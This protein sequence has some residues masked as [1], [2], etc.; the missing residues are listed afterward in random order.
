M[1]ILWLINIELPEVSVLLKEKENPWG[2]WLVNASADLAV[3]EGIQLSIA[4]PKFGLTNFL[5]LKGENIQFYAFP[6]IL[7]SDQGAI[8][9]SSHLK[10]ILEQ[11]KPDIVHIFGT[12]FA[13]S[14]AM[15][16]LC[17][18]LKIETIISI[19]GLLSVISRHYLNGLPER[20]VNRLTF[21]DFIKH[22]GLKQQQFKFRK[23]GLLEIKA[24]Q[25]VRHI[26]GRTTWDRACT[27]QINPEAIYHSCNETLRNEFYNHV[28]DINKC[29]KHTIFASQASYPVKGLHYLLEAMP[30]ILKEF[31]DTKLYVAGHDITRTVTIKDKLKVS[32]YSKY[33]IELID[34]IGLHDKV[35]F[36]GLLDESQMCDRYLK[37]HVFVSSSTIENSPNSLCEA[38]LLGVPCVASNVG[39]VPDL[40]RD[41]LDGFLYQSDAP[42]MLAYHV[43]QLFNDQ[44]LA[45]AISASA[46]S[47]ATITHNREINNNSLLK[48]YRVACHE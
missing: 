42:Y 21:R 10:K 27:S 1:N 39:G 4:Y 28:W 37:S 38:M 25:K 20:V 18:E 2:G 5:S 43:C 22:D 15:V 6:Q 30:L 47:R 13:H 31:P 35:I 34:K 26:I 36:T 3:Q 48:I 16:N 17:R 24:L 9:Q 45:L 40:L 44:N 14:L 29:E 32:S 46:R 33:I 41:K 8:N 23:R 11:S 12:E 19:Q 7:H